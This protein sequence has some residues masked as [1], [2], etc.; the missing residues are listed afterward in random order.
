MIARL[1]LFREFIFTK[2]DS[3]IIGSFIFDITI[4]KRLTIDVPIMDRPIIFITIIDI[5]LITSRIID[6]PII[7]SPLASVNSSWTC[8]TTVLEFLNNLWDLGNE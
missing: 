4:I 2:T 6:N 5:Q 7:I 1:S 8:P 3:S